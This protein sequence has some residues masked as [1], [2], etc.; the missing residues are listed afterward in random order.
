[1]TNSEI[2]DYPTPVTIYGELKEKQL[3]NYTKYIIEN[4]DTKGQDK[5]YLLLTR[6][7]NWQCQDVNIG[8]KGYFTF[9]YIIAGV[10]KWF[11][12]YSEG[13]P[14]NFYNS[15]HLAFVNF[16]P[17]SNGIYKKNE[18]GFKIKIN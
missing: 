15:T 2:E 4:L 5:E 14:H 18:D 16:V 11:D 12:R 13:N 1:M 3:D 7:P 10:S 6:Y 8:D 17:D 9:Y